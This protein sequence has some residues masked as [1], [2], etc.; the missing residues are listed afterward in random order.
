[1]LDE[2]EHR[3]A[4]VRYKELRPGKLGL[5]Y[6]LQV[7]LQGIAAKACRSVAQLVQLCALQGILVIEWK[8]D[9]VAQNLRPEHLFHAEFGHHY[10]RKVER[11][12]V[13]Q[14]ILPVPLSCLVVGAVAASQC[15]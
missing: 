8:D 3:I 14:E 15:D 10:S 1:M 12:L 2:F 6:E 9:T 13:L 4:V 5:G 11:D 7:V